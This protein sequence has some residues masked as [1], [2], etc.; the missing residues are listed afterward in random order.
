MGVNTL[1]Q[2]M[3]MVSVPNPDV[4]CSGHSEEEIRKTLTVWHMADHQWHQVWSEAK[5]VAADGSKGK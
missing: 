1:E 4:L 2:E 3:N 5:N